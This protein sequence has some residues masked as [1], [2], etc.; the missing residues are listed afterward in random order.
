MIREELR[1][2]GWNLGGRLCPD[3][4]NSFCAGNKKQI[5]ESAGYALEAYQEKV[6]PWFESLTLEKIQKEI[7]R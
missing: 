5:E 3:G 4:S 1:D 7:N 6:V 2:S